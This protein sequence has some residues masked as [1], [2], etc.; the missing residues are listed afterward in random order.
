MTGDQSAFA[1]PKQECDLVMK[2]GITSGVVYPRLILTLAQKRRLRNVGG[3]SA[4]AIAAGLAAAAEWARD[5]GGF[6]RLAEV[7]RVFEDHLADLFQPHSKHRKLFGE[8]LELAEKKRNPFRSLPSIVR[9][10]PL[11]WRAKK[12]LKRLPDTWYGLCPGTTQRTRRR[13]FGLHKGKLPAVPGL[14]DWLD[15]ELEWVAGRVEARGQV[16]D[17][18]LTFGMLAQAGVTLRTVAT[19]LSGRQ[20]VILPFAQ[21]TW[22]F[23]PDELRQLFPER[24]VDWLVERG[25]EVTRDDGTVVEGYRS[26]PAADDLPVLL[27]VRLSLS[28]PLLLSA[29]PLYRLDRTLR[30]DPQAM[31]TPRVCWLSDGGITSNFPVHLFDDLLP[32]RPTFGISLDGYD[33]RRHGADR[34][35]MPTAAGGGIQRPIEPMGGLVAFAASI[36][37]SARNW[38]DSLQ[39]VLPGYRERIVHIALDDT[40]GGLNLTMPAEVIT[41]LAQY[42]DQAGKTLSGFDFDEH[43]WRRFLSTYSALEETMESARRGW[44]GGF[45]EFLETVEPGSYKASPE[46]LAELRR[47]FDALVEAT[48]SWGERPLRHTWGRSGSGMPRPRTHVK[49]VPQEQADVVDLDA[50]V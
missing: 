37:D 38:Q 48:R 28:F 44:D 15:Q 40:E 42:G 8:L 26:L 11:L 13:W 36:L 1:D 50:E 27:G 43:R 6:E 19:D 21:R 16:P 7:P 45:A 20:P 22:M 10:V 41:N 29:I 39:S 31:E 3:T 5:D 30:L 25:E 12:S 4:G 23:R 17:T 18:P 33:A 46:D 24:V 35:W 9:S 2:G 14:T 47:R 49:L 34:V 32:S